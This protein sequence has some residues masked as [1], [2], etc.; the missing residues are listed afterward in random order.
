VL[1]RAAELATAL[2]ARV[3]VTSVTPV[4]SYT[5]HG[6]GPYDPADPPLRHREEA[7]DAAARLAELGV[8]GVEAVTGLG[9]PG[10]TI[11]AMAGERDVDL[12]VIGA[13][14]RGLLTH[15]L[16]GSVEDTVVRKAPT[17]VLVVH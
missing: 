15:L 4:L 7:L 1:E 6:V 9:D 5:G 13:S 3:I 8:S 12:I 16:T 11:V 2:H 17:D 10:R 14:D